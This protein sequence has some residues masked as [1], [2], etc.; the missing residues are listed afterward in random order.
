[1]FDP[2]KPYA[3]I[4]GLPPGVAVQSIPCKDGD[5]YTDQ[6]RVV[7]HCE[8]GVRTDGPPPLDLKEFGASEPIDLSA[9][10]VPKPNSELMV[11]ALIYGLYGFPVGLGLWI[12]YRVVRFAVKG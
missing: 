3:S 2:S 10:I 11:T 7:W 4:E 9:G 6:G 1:V 12:F 5:A 8:N